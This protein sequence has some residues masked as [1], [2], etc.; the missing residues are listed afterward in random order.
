MT[1]GNS[2]NVWIKYWKKIVGVRSKHYD[3]PGGAVGREFVDLL[4]EE[5]TLLCKGKE[6]SERF[7]VFLAVILQRDTMVTKT[8]DIC[9]VFR[10]RIDLWRHEQFDTLIFEF[11]RCSKIQSNQNQFRAQIK[12]ILKSYAQ[13]PT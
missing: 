1:G 9:R 13:R 8:I 5:V 10:H 11:L 7:I 3:V 4:A 12:G 6:I 2:K